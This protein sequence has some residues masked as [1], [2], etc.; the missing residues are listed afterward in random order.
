MSEELPPLQSQVSTAEDYSIME[1]FLIQPDKSVVLPVPSKA[2]EKP[3]SDIQIMVA[4]KAMP[5]V[6]QTMHMGIMR[7]ANSQESAVQE[8]IKKARRT[9]HSL[10]GAGLHGENGLDPDTSIHLLQTY[11]IP[12]LV[13]GLEVVLPTGVYLD[14]LDRVHKKVHQTDTFIT[15]EC[16]RPSHI[17]YSRSTSSGSNYTHQSPWFV[18]QCFSS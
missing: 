8:N 16:S 14:K 13:Y 4:D 3:D 17:Y 7:S 9:V 1:E 11:V 2:A 12:I 15:P 6:T 18:W 10:M 5:V